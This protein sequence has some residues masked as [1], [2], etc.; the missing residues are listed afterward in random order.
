ME[1]YLAR[2]G[3]KYF[4]IETAI[5]TFASKFVPKISGCFLEIDGCEIEIGRPLICKNYTKIILPDHSIK[6]IM[7]KEAEEDIKII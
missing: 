3:E 6:R 2:K 4:E 7:Q 5:G 1:E